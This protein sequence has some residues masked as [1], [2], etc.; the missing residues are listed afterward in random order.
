MG[1]LV[2]IKGTELGGDI[3]TVD[4]YHTSITGSN[5]ISSSVTAAQ[6]TG[7]GITF[8]VAD[9]VT[10]FYAYVS[11]GLCLGTSGS[12]TSSVYTPNT[13]Y[14][15]FGVSGSN[16]ELGTI[17]MISPFSIGPTQTLFT[18]SVNFNTYAS[19]TIEAVSDTYPNDQFQGWYY[20]GESTPF[21]DSG[22]T[23]LTL[24]LNTYTGSDDIVAYFKDIGV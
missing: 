10:T 7:S 14:F 8:E 22:S 15:T 2:K 4:I 11:G 1:K 17:E 3:T 24:T 6:L 19:V 18:A 20:A 16:N 9:D 13:R 23:T 5:L 12:I 21:L